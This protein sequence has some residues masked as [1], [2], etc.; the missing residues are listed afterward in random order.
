MLFDKTINNFVDLAQLFLIR[1][2]CRGRDLDDI[3]QV[4]EEFLLDSFFQALV[5][6]VVK[7]L[8]LACQGRDANKNL[9]TERALG[10]LCNTN[11]LFN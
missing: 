10:I 8:T 7:A 4:G 6:G 3:T 2:A 9:F 1:C 5:T 11:L